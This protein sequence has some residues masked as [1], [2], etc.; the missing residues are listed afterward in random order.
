MTAA[1]AVLG[2]AALV[3]ILARIA[4][5]VGA[6]TGVMAVELW[7][8]VAWVILLGW[9]SVLLAY[10]RWGI[11]AAAAL[12]WVLPVVGYAAERAVDQAREWLAMARVHARERGWVR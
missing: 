3:L 4:W 1:L 9:M 10:D 12:W 11:A 5:H 2:G 8:I 7:A 6:H